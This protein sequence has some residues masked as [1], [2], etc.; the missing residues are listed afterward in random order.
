[1]I[2]PPGHGSL[3]YTSRVSSYDAIA[4]RIKIG[5]GWPQIRVELTDEQIY[6]C[7]DAA[8]EYYTQFAGTTE[9]YL[10][11]RSDLYEPGVGLNLMLLFNI[12]PEMKHSINNPSLSALSAGFDPDLNNFRKV[13]GVFSFAESTATGNNSLLTLEYTIAQQTYFGSML[14][15]TGFDLVTWHILKDWIETREKMFGH[16]PY[17]RFDPDTQYLK[18]IPEPT[19]SSWGY[20]YGVLGCHVTKPLKDIVSNLW[21]RRYAEAKCRTVLGYIRQKIGGTV[22]F[23]GNTVNGSDLL[24]KGNEDMAK[25][26]E[27]LQQKYVYNKPPRFFIG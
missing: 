16:I 19:T 20:Y 26:E 12:S 22:L 8:C 23:G 5:M 9:E 21:V 13:V 3:T 14:G 15:K 18:L 1:M 6:E 4:N 25:L 7:I 24:A 2:V 17:F 27:E 10:I 11:F